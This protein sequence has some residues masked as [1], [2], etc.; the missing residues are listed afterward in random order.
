MY[1]CICIYGAG[2]QA[3]AGELE[4]LEAFQA[5][6]AAVISEGEERGEGEME[7]D[8]EDE[9]GHSFDSDNYDSDDH[10][11]PSTTAPVPAEDASV[12]GSEVESSEES[13]DDS[14][15]NNE[16]E[17]EQYG[18]S[19]SDAEN[20]GDMA[21]DDDLDRELSRMI[22]VS[23]SP[24]LSSPLLSPPP[25]SLL[26]SSV[27]LHDRLYGFQYVPHTMCMQ[28]SVDAR[29][30]QQS[31][32]RATLDLL[33]MPTL[34]RPGGVGGVS[35]GVGSVGRSGADTVTLTLVNRQR[36]KPGAAPRA[37]I[38]HELIVPRAI[39]LANS[40][41]RSE[42]EQRA[43]AQLLK[44]RTLQLHEASEMAS[45]DSEYRAMKVRGRELAQHLVDTRA[46]EEVPEGVDG[47][48]DSDS[49]PAKERGGRGRGRGGRGGRG[50][51]K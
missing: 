45:R 20:N 13:S 18:S 14:D 44:Q 43:E 8:E 37:P 2:V 48:E 29:R 12:G 46:K 19:E 26:L 25:S 30:G 5:A 39:A 31:T 4:K 38:M 7:E 50:R 21:D 32:A 42:A 16:F 15:A 11:L 40:A 35:G 36:G 22:K 1:A 33:S 9:D 17:E 47:E 6:E 34:H 49:S 10:P 41:M 24:L 28:D 3:A 27:P 51:G 23:V